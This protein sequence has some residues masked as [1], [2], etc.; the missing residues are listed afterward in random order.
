MYNVNANINHNLTIHPRYIYTGRM[1]YNACKNV[2]WISLL[3]GASKLELL[4]LLT[5][6]E[7][8]LIDKQKDWIEH[9]ILTVHKYA[10]STVSLNK[11]LAYCNRIMA[12]HPD[13]IFKSNDL[14][15]LPKETLITLLKS[16]ELSMDEDDI[17]MSVIQWATKQVS[18][19]ELGND[20]DDWS[21]DDLNTVKDI[22][23]DCIPHIRFFNISPD[24]VSLYYNLLPRKLCRDLFSYQINKNYKPK[25]HMLPP[26]TGQ[27]YIDSIIINKEQAKWIFSKIVESTR[28]SYVYKSTLLYRCS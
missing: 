3:D 14:A 16:D 18:E 20:P 6:I 19:L 17:L 22:V 15:T 12:S 11:L 28:Q 13:I 26:R 24:K 21:S 10:A 7:T 9:N 4:D 27:G 23:A 25:T 1:S 8:C 5:G 2:G